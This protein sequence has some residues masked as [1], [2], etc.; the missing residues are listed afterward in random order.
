M[1]VRRRPS[2]L[3][4]DERAVAIEIADRRRDEALTIGAPAV[5]VLEQRGLVDLEVE[6]LPRRIG[7]VEL[8]HRPTMVVRLAAARLRRGQRRAAFRERAGLEVRTLGVLA[9]L[10]ELE[11]RF[12]LLRPLRVVHERGDRDRSEDAE[13]LEREQDAR[14]DDARER[15]SLAPD[16]ATRAL[17]LV[18]AHDREDEADR[19]AEE[20]AD[21]AGDREAGRPAGG[22]NGRIG[23]CHRAGTLTCTRERTR[24]SAARAASGPRSP[25]GCPRL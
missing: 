20:R 16:R 7:C 25:P 4:R 14:D 23:G 11:R 19:T 9:E 12:G 13:D 18:A 1:A 17:A 10:V 21:E 2:Q 6:G 5:G 15:E 24:T 22:H 8:R 3:V